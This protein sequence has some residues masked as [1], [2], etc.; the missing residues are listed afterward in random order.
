VYNSFL[1]IARHVALPYFRY[2]EVRNIKSTCNPKMEHLGELI[3]TALTMYSP[4]IRELENQTK[5]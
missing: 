2:N 1:H 5:T 4:E 3:R